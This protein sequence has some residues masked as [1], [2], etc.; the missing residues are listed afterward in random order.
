[1]DQRDGSLGGVEQASGAPISQ[2]LL[3]WAEQTRY[4]AD[5]TRCDR[6]IKGWHKAFC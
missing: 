1:M 4:Q 6:Q 3:P 5:F 2:F